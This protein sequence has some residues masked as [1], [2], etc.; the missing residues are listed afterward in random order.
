[1]KKLI[2]LGDVL[3]VTTG[4]LVSDNGITGLKTLVEYMWGQQ[5]PLIFQDNAVS[6]CRGYLL[7]QH[8]QLQGITGD[9]SDSY[10]AGGL[11]AEKLLYGDTLEVEDFT[12]EEKAI[13]AKE[14]ERLPHEARIM[15]IDRKRLDGQ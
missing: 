8:P 2:P 11:A 7:F 4:K 12:D 15:G 9:I 5:V 6:D 10:R 1:M 14:V 3:S 13:L